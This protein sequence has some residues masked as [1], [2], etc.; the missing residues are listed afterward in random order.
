MSGKR[1]GKQGKAEQDVRGTNGRI[2]RLVLPFV[3]A[4]VTTVIVFLTSSR[5]SVK[6]PDGLQLVDTGQPQLVTAVL[7]GLGALLVTAV[8]VGMMTRPTA[9]SSR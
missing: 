1:G 5:G 7:A 2:L 6:S 8:V 9:R 4:I 3:V